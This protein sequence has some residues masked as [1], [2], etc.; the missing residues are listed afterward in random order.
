MQ[1]LFTSN[2]SFGPKL[3]ADSGGV[4]ATNGT[5]KTLKPLTGVL[6][7]EPLLSGSTFAGKIQSVRSLIALHSD[8]NY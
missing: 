1:S 3:Q 2:R 6:V 7:D 5:Q 8:S 4:S